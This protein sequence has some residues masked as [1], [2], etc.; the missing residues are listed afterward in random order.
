L[1]IPALLQFQELI[2]EDLTGI[3]LLADTHKP[4]SGLKSVL[5]FIILAH[6]R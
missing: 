5:Q 1:K 4:C 3:G 6:M 2:A